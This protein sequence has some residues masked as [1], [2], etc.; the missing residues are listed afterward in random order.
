MGLPC[1]GC[2]LTRAFACLIH[3]DLSGAMR[4]HFL[5][6]VVLLYLVVWY[7]LATI[8]LFRPFEGPG[9]WRRAGNGL[10]VALVILYCGRMVA[11]F[12]SPEGLLSPV[13]QN[14]TARLIRWDWSNTY[15]PWAR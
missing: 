6:P 4:F 7:V 2:G 3:F 5:A 13:K 9:W 12:S 8:R 1:L 11:F 15:E 10:I 14:M